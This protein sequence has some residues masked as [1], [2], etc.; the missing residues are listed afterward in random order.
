MGEGR[1]VCVVE[2]KWVWGEGVGMKKGG[3]SVR[4]REGVSM[5]KRGGE[6]VKTFPQVE[7]NVIGKV[8][9]NVWPNEKYC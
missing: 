6:R 5:L 3:V 7:H 4:G 9:V 8:C 2:R 1:S